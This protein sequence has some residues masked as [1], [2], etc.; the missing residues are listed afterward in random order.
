M[1]KRERQQTR[2]G[3]PRTLSSEEARSSPRALT[4]SP[5]SLDARQRG[6]DA[7][8]E[9]WRLRTCAFRFQWRAEQPEKFLNRHKKASARMG[10]RT[11]MGL[12]ISVLW[13]LLVLLLLSASLEAEVRCSSDF[14]F[15]ALR[16]LRIYRYQMIARSSIRLRPQSLL[17][18]S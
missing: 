14:L 5:R 12:R 15:R 1:G 4:A 18:Y 8:D 11:C 6:K 2:K 9:L 16:V 10:V 13:L 7:S 3:L 17:D